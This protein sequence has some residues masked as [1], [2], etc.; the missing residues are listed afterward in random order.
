LNENASLKQKLR[1]SEEKVSMWQ[2]E[3]DGF[4]VKKDVGIPYNQ[5]TW[6]SLISEN[7][8]MNSFIKEIKAE[9]EK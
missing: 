9:I 3:L 4:Q 5:E 7:K 2:S 6:N 1:E 8:E